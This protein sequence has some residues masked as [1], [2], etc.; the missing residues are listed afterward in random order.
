VTTGITE[1]VVP[2]CLPVASPL[3]DPAHAFFVPT[4]QNNATSPVDAQ[5][6]QF[7]VRV[8]RFAGEYGERADDKAG[9]QK[10]LDWGRQ[11]INAGYGDDQLKKI[12][13][14]QRGIAELRAD[15]RAGRL[16]EGQAAQQLHAL[17]RHF[18]SE[19]AR[20][21]QAQAHNAQ[22]GAVLH[23]TGRMV[24]A[25][26]IQTLG[27]AIDPSLNIEQKKAQIAGNAKDSVA[28]LPGQLLFGAMGGA[29]GAMV[30]PSN[31]L[32]DANPDAPSTQQLLDAA[33]VQGSFSAADLQRMQGWR[34]TM[35]DRLDTGVIDAL[36]GTPFM[37]GA[38]LSDEGQ[39]RLAR[40]QQQLS[41]E[42][43]VP[44]EESVAALQLAQDHWTS[45]IVNEENA[46]E[47][48]LRTQDA[49]T[50]AMRPY[51]ELAALRNEY[52]AR[53]DVLSQADPTF[54]EQRIG[55]TRI[56]DDG[57]TL[58][59]I[60]A[61]VAPQDVAQQTQL[62]ALRL[63]VVQM[64]ERQHAA[65]SAA[66]LEQGFSQAQY[67]ELT[68]DLSA[69]ALA[70][71][72]FR[73]GPTMTLR[74]AVQPYAMPGFRLS[75]EQLEQAVQ[76]NEPVVRP[77]PW[78]LLFGTSPIERDMFY[79]L[80]FANRA[81]AVIRLNEA[82][83]RLPL[84][85]MQIRTAD[86]DRRFDIYRHG[87]EASGTTVLDEN[88]RAFPS[89]RGAV[90]AVLDELQITADQ[91]GQLVVSFGSG[92]KV[93]SNQP[94]M[95]WSRADADSYLE[96]LRAP[97]AGSDLN[98]L[99]TSQAAALKQH[100]ART[101]PHD[102]ALAYLLMADRTSD[103]WIPAWIHDAESPLAPRVRQV[104]I[105]AGLVSAQTL[106]SDI[107][108]VA[109][110]V[111]NAAQ[112]EALRYAQRLTL[113]P[114]VQTG[115]RT[116]EEFV[117]SRRSVAE[118]LDYIDPLR[119]AEDDARGFGGGVVG[120]VP[121]AFLPSTWE[122]LA[123][124]DDRTIRSEQTLALYVQWTDE[125]FN[126]WYDLDREGISNL[127]RPRHQPIAQ[128][129]LASFERIFEFD[130]GQSVVMQSYDEDDPP[131]PLTRADLAGS[132]RMAFVLDCLL[133]IERQLESASGDVPAIH[134]AAADWLSLYD[135]V[136]QMPRFDPYADTLM[137]QYNRRFAAYGL[138]MDR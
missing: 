127:D 120:A 111:F 48:A 76:N 133:P 28:Q 118:Y 94:Q 85:P 22:M 53:V 71:A 88:G 6:D 129:L 116:L 63:Q 137:K 82:H 3:S 75:A 49:L 43:G 136:L 119:H 79:E 77:Q 93:M 70:N 86:N 47:R 122:R 45:Q 18:E 126:T 60:E 41:A 17:Q 58:G 98:E 92:D 130:D 138:A 59:Q 42:T 72:Q 44:V 8:D 11:F 38:A 117:T 1:Q 66:A 84:E 125:L 87:S 114:E 40:A 113:P 96:A 107:G 36:V 37:E 39:Q 10:A 74:D 21:E 89:P 62:V 7:E 90:Q 55:R 5:L 32:A 2:S 132:N 115:Q 106:E 108:A 101:R 135:A 97:L 51:R 4:L 64:L 56:G 110:H 73:L 128:H 121:Q 61:T 65:V 134:R 30:K 100:A 25:L 52:A 69:P 109:D 57:V 102:E 29:G 27:T 23:G 131:E 95:Y 14:T 16:D 26:G 124:T 33:G 67:E 15:V 68:A 35:D 20:V 46:F 78:Q 12:G 31:A 24:T 9:V 123:A 105:D 80:D 112:A 83:R 54:D 99:S 19:G 34:M 103:S 50:Q 104:L 81:Q 13:Q 91:S